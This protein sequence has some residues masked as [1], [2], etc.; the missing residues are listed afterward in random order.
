[1]KKGQRKANASVIATT[2]TI[3]V[4]GKYDITAKRLSQTWVEGSSKGGDFHV[5]LQHPPNFYFGEGH[6]T[7]EQ[8]AIKRAIM[9]LTNHEFTR[10][11][12]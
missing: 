6:D 3:T 5:V 12:R 4:K 8:A 10:A 2:K 9:K 7:R 1:M 11:G